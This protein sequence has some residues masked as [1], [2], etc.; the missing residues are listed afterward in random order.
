MNE[1][2]PEA[3]FPGGESPVP[4]MTRDSAQDAGDGRLSTA[5]L[6]VGD[7]TF[8]S[9]SLWDVIG[10]GVRAPRVTW[11]RFWMVVSQPVQ[12]K[13]ADDDADPPQAMAAAELP[14]R[15]VAARRAP[16]LERAYVL[17]LI[18]LLAG[19]A[20]GLAG[21][22]ILASGTNRAETQELRAGAPWLLLAFVL[23]IAGEVLIYRS[24]LAFG[25]R[26]PAMSVES[27]PLPAGL[28]VE[29][30][31]R[32]N[33]LAW[34]QERSPRLTLAGIG[35]LLS[36]GAYLFNGSN[37]FSLVGVVAWAG[38]LIVWLLAL[39][40]DDFSLSAWGSRA[41]ARLRFALRLEWRVRL[42]WTALALC[43][44]MAVGAYFRFTH[45]NA[46]PPEMTSDHVEKLL[47]A[48]RVL[49][50]T[51]QIFFPNNGGR[52]ALQ[53]YL[54]ALFS[55]VSG[56][57]MQFATL[58]WVSVLEGLLTLPVLWWMGREII[59][60]KQPR[61]GNLVGLLMAALVAVSYWH[62]ALSRLALR[63]V[64]TPLLMALI[65]IF[66]ARG[67]RRNSRADFLKTGVALGVGLYSYQAVRMIPVVIVLGVALA[68]FFRARRAAERRRYVLNLAALVMISV[69]IFVPLGRFM[70][71]SPNLFW[72]RTA[73]RFFGD[74]VIM[75]TDPV[76][77]ELVERNA[78]ME[79]RLEAFKGN[80]PVLGR[81][82]RNVL[83]MFNWKGD[84]AWINGAPNR[85]AMDIVTGTFLIVGSAAWLVRMVR[86]RDVVDWLVLP[87]LFVMLMP[88]ALSIAFPVENPSATRTSGSL[89]FAYLLA[90]YGMAV[91]VSLMQK[92]IQRR[93]AIVLPAVLV[94]GLI[95]TAYGANSALYFGPY[96]D[97]YAIAAQPYSQTGRIL[98]GFADSNGSYGN[99]F[100]VAYPYWLDHRA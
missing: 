63:I 96:R 70:I 28:E 9:L 68:F 25:W 41:L 27:G 40:P 48:Q 67:L 57:G 5:V 1:Y 4:E 71:D 15:R 73:G 78:T 83:L 34:L 93:G 31:R 60:E 2:P 16:L 21:S 87:A 46:V 64:L 95:G 100:M 86:R 39:A 75:E 37:A 18:L 88:S 43:V 19:L 11:R 92:T 80:L 65:M 44:I 90:A 53:M 23:W 49:D 14:V 10:L 74:D 69:V 62:V 91:L 85:P 79:D 77:G 22:G 52:E 38:S 20:F 50:G 56:L 61:L 24:R 17:P 51:H 58:K 29:E 97:A 7:D 76:T 84:V 26:R 35:V 3:E 54:V 66:L 30:T 94:V 47:D 89:P 81:N 98:R 42:S 33:L 8:T 82:I 45:F 99:A 12:L 55:V 32:F 6:D 36:T 59:G 72:M 13:P